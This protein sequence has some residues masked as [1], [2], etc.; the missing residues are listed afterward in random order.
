MSSWE[1]ANLV[2]YLIIIN[3]CEWQTRS[4]SLLWYCRCFG[5]CVIVNGSIGMMVVV[6]VMMMRTNVVCVA[7]HAYRCA[8]LSILTVM[9][10]TGRV[11]YYFSFVKVK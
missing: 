4:S 2:E 9:M 3:N 11:S 6:M 10:M 8:I 5:M 7:A 1:V